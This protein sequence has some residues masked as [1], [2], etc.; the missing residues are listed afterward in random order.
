MEAYLDNAATTRVDPEA[1][2]LMQN[3]FLK[4]FGNPSS[5][6]KMGFEAEQYVNHALDVFSSAMKCKKKNLIFTSG[7]TES[8]NTA[9]IG[10]ALFRE[11]RG[12]HII[13]TVV[14]HAA[15]SEPVRF[16]ESRG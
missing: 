9:I 7:G 16:L 10:T 2:A 1:A 13:T 14:E 15:V 6:H 5:L 3:I 11:R 12:K 8:N 4:D